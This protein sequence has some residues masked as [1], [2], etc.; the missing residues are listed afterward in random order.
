MSDERCA[1]TDMEKASCAH[2]R[3]KLPR[4]VFTAK[5]DS[6]CPT[7]GNPLEAGQQAVWTLDGTT[8]EHAR[9]AR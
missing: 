2:C 3:E 8:A 5:L 1:L 9:H 4:P 6:T 7:C